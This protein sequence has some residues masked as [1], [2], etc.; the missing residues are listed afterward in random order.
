MRDDVHDESDNDIVIICLLYNEC[1]HCFKFSTGLHEVMLSKGE[2]FVSQPFKAYYFPFAQ[3]CSRPNHFHFGTSTS[4]PPLPINNACSLVPTVK[5]S[6]LLYRPC[7]PL[8]LSQQHNNLSQLFLSL[9]QGSLHLY[10]K[11][12]Q[13]AFSPAQIGKLFR[14]KMFLNLFRNIFASQKAKFC[15]RKK[16]FPTWADQEHHW[17]HNVSQFTQGRFDCEYE[18]RWRAQNLQSFSFPFKCF[19]RNKTNLQEIKFL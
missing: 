12:D 10:E 7:Q 11:R 2:F 14:N 3:P 13:G 1:W 17:K 9:W 5:S 18:I 8:M 6:I 19:F 4:T 16:C 15:F